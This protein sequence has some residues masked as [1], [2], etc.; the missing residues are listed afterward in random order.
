[1]ISQTVHTD[2]GGREGK[3]VALS[4][5]LILA[6]A[7]ILLPYHQETVQQQTLSPHQV[8]IKDLAADEL[9]MIAELRLAHEEIRN[10]HQDS[11]ELD[12]TESWA[13]IAELEAL[14]LAP[15]I[16]DKGWER[17]GKH[18]WFKISPALYQG[19][20]QLESGSASVV[21]NSMQEEPD[22]WL[23]LDKTIQ[24]VISGDIRSERVPLQTRVLIE[25][26]WKQVVFADNGVI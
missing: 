21:L 20:P 18:L 13:D 2:D 19:V 22:I 23:H 9:A 5:S 4:I 10:L 14:W 16:Q 8:F 3:W 15:F 1:M 12:G 24:P 11:V 17:K 26:G 6:V 7:A 25:T